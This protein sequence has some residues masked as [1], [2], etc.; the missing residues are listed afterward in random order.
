MSTCVF[1]G[2]VE[3]PSS[4]TEGP[5]IQLVVS[6]NPELRLTIAIDLPCRERAQ[7]S[8]IAMVPRHIGRK[9]NGSPQIPQVK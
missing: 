3:G 5:V 2:N 1:W 8:V 4:G 7:Y 6:G 9:A